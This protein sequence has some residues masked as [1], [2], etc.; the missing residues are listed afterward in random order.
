MNLLISKLE[1]FEVEN[2]NFFNENS[3]NSE[4]EE[5]ERN[6]LKQEENESKN[7]PR[8]KTHLN[9]E[10]LVQP[11]E[12]KINPYTIWK[13]LKTIIGK[14]HLEIETNNLSAKET[15][16]ENEPINSLKTTIVNTTNK[17]K[18]ITFPTTIKLK[19][20][21]IKVESMLDTRVSKNLNLKL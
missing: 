21:K 10:K 9:L 18:L 6:Y 19:K 8:N 5:K 20:T 17:V 15:Q 4:E 16:K 1:F 3:L 2:L 12:S 7:K 14:T 11:L 13:D